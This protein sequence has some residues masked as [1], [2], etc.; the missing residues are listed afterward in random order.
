MTNVNEWVNKK[1]DVHVWI[2]L[3]RADNNFFHDVVNLLCGVNNPGPYRDGDNSIGGLIWWKND[4]VFKFHSV[5]TKK[6]TYSLMEQQCMEW[7]ER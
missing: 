1:G 2:I 6:I 7:R 3:I 4:F 5:K